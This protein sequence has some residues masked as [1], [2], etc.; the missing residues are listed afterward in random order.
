M[1]AGLDGGR[2]MRFSLFVY[3][4][5]KL[6]GAA[7]LAMFAAIDEGFYARCASGKWSE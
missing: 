6:G 5:I 4:Q 2:N 1:A 7:F 3:E